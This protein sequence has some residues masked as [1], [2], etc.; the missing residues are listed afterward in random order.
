M[1]A[2]SLLGLS[3]LTVSLAVVAARAPVPQSSLGLF[4]GETD[5]G[6]VTKRGSVTY[7]AGRDQY[8]LAGSGANMW[9]DRDDFHFVWKRIQGN[10]IVA[11]RARFN[12][13]GVEPHRKF[14]WSVRA[15][16]ES[17]SPHVTAA[18]HGD[19]LVALQFRRSAGGATEEIRS[20]VTGADIIQLER[21]G[22]S[23][24]LSV[25]RFG[26]SLAPVRI[27]DLAL[28]D[29]AYVGLFVCAHND[30][31]VERATFRDVRITAPARDGFVP[32]RDYIGSNLEILDVVTGDRTIV[33][34]SP[35][36]IQAPNWTMDGKALIYNS[37]GSVYRF[38]L[39]DRRPIAVNTGFAT[40]NNNDHVL[41]FDGRTLGISHH[42]SDDH[43]A[44]IVYI[45]PVGGGTPRRVTSR[46]P[47]YLHGWSPDGRFLVYTGE[48]G[49]AFDV[50]RIS[51]AGGDETRLT[52]APGLDDGPEYSPDG[53]YIYFNSARN[54]TMQIW[55]MR[56]DG[57]AQEQVTSDQFN[58][59]FP[60]VSP[61]GQW[62][63]FL[64]FM[65]DVAPD[66]HPFYKHVYLRL[67]RAG[68]DGSDARV[69]GYVYG[70]QGTINV[71]S[72]SPDSRRVAFVSNSDL[73]RLP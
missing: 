34:R 1:R 12:G 59:W 71:P 26:D 50:Y 43:D 8:T 29:Q 13:P 45:V 37:Q 72:W 28:G 52:N 60:H 2:S 48:R 62:I 16:L 35:E 23:Y 41:S 11:A 21:T 14:G 18:V 42:S 36:S 3:M 51:V 68:G 25:G 24:V 4:Q 66:D 56:A 58:N 70:G 31:V 44:S 47:S 7:D 54:G 61:D 64:S 6:Q 20:P 73:R 15:S 10:F 67:M 30:T 63:V 55:R 17:G 49:G 40:R 5:V 27:A 69:V 19:G 57:S 38:D 32:Y 53:R 46:G 22:D 33:Y 65:K 39:A 9:F